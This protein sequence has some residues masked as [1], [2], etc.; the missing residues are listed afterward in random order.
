MKRGA[1]LGQHFLNNP[2][3]ARAL[4][5]AAQITP[6][7][8]VLEIGPGEGALTAELLKTG[9][10]VVA[11][12]KDHTLVEKLKHRFSTEVAAKTLT[13]V[14]EDVRNFVASQYLPLVDTP[15][16]LA[17]N[18]P[19][20]ITGEIIRQFLESENQPKTIAFQ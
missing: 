15:Y 1:R 18:I 19:Y 5:A 12:E 3:Y 4:V 9:A 2:F 16:I 10:R 17:A 14:A 6:V 7:D 11:I 13:I 20:Y 8:T